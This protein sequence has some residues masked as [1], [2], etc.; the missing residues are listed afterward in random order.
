MFEELP[1]ILG[2]MIFSLIL[3]YVAFRYVSRPFSQIITALA[4]I[5]IIIHEIC[6][7][8][9]CV[10]TRSPVEDVTLVKKL[11]F[12]EE[13]RLGYYGEV[14]VQE[15]RISFLQAILIGFAPLYLSFWLF[16]FLLE[17]LLYTQVNTVVFIICIFLMISISFSAAP[18]FADFLIIPR[19]FL[20]DYNHSM[21]QIFLIV[22]SFLLTFIV[23]TIFDLQG[24]HEFIVYLIVTGFYFGFKYGFRFTVYLLHNNRFTGN[25]LSNRRNFR[26]YSKR[27]YN[28][29]KRKLSYCSEFKE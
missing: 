21:Y 22:L 5:G 17:V 23:L 1:F 8:V 6:H 11:D 3:S 19:V 29:E 18:S 14:K 25:I 12:K 7:Y 4:V 28:P 20:N 26:R 15:H 24:F 2:F 10:V 27:G 16:F 13:Q 9:M